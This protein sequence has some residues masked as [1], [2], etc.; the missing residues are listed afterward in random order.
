VHHI[1][2]G[3]FEM[4]SVHCSRPGLNRAYLDYRNSTDKKLLSDAMHSFQN[5]YSQAGTPVL[6]APFGGDLQEGCLPNG[7]L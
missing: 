7:L 3:P 5:A 6:L 1:T 4:R 2:P